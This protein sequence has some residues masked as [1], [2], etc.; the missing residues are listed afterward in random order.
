[1]RAPFLQRSVV[2]K[3]KTVLPLFV[4][5]GGAALGYL[6][7]LAWQSW[8]ESEQNALTASNADHLNEDHPMRQSGRDMVDEASWESFPASDSPARY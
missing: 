1:M 6:G 2:M 7:Y 8:S 3:T 5:V 4:V